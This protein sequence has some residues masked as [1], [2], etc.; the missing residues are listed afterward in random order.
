MWPTTSQTC[1]RLSCRKR[2]CNQSFLQWAKNG[3]RLLYYSLITCH[4]KAGTAFGI[5]PILREQY[6]FHLGLGEGKEIQYLLLMITCL[7]CIYFVLGYAEWKKVGKS[8][9]KLLASSLVLEKA[10]KLFPLIETA[11]ISSWHRDNKATHL[12]ILSTQAKGTM[13]V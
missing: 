11:V 10:L 4:S 5:K 8:F 3:V 13:P 12:E 6:L 9:K 2:T 1:Q 7:G